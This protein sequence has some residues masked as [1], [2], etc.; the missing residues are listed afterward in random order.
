MSFRWARWRLPSWKVSRACAKHKRNDYVTHFP[1]KWLV[2]LQPYQNIFTIKSVIELG[3]SMLRA[4]FPALNEA[5]GSAVSGR[6]SEVVV[7]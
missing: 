3:L 6:S 4:C 7:F 1:A 5:L 2:S